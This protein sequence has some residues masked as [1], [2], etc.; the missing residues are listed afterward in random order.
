MSEKEKEKRKLEGEITG[1]PR[2]KSDPG[3]IRSTQIQR[4]L[5]KLKWELQLLYQSETAYEMSKRSKS[6]SVL[7]SSNR[8]LRQ[9]LLQAK[10]KVTE[11]EA[12]H[13]RQ[14]EAV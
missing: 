12:I 7:E 14:G 6:L 11:M 5:L 3:R 10:Q 13:K 1:R 2:S 9:A 4:D 8:D